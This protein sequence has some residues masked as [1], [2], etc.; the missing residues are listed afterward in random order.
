MKKNLFLLSLAAFSFFSCSSDAGE[1]EPWHIPVM[2]GH[3]YQIELDGLNELSGICLSKDGNTLFGVDDEGKL[4]EIQLQEIISKIE[5]KSLTET[6]KNGSPFYTTSSSFTKRLSQDGMEG[7]A[8]DPSG[9]LYISLEEEENCICRIENKSSGY[10][11]TNPKLMGPFDYASY[12]N[13]GTEG[14]TW[15]S[16]NG[17]DY[18]YVGTQSGSKVFKYTLDGKLAG[19]AFSL[20]DAEGWPE[21]EEKIS[22]IAGLDYDSKNNLLW[23]IDSEL[24]TI[25]LFKGD[26]S[27]LLASYNIK[28]NADDNPEGLCIDRKRKCI[29]VCEDI[30]DKSIL[31]KYSFDCL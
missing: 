17:K 14:I 16:E 3:E 15:Y 8:I 18:L 7:L 28:A 9:N 20:R 25:Y 19:E 2:V 5:S 26:G 23:A 1:E 27:E 4:Y 29:W 13:D 6:V 22:E 30:S 11:F 21:G 10:D 12:G 31:H 24:F